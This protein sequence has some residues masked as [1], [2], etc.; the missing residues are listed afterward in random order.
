MT[1]QL[2]AIGPGLPACREYIVGGTRMTAAKTKT[3]KSYSS[4]ARTTSAAIK[5]WSDHI[6]QLCLFLIQNEGR[7]YRDNDT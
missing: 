5:H 3:A 2:H 4:T 7:T 1:V 6:G